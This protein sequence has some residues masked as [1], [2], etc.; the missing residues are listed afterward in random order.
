MRKHQSIN[1]RQI[2]RN[3]A[4]QMAYYRFL[5]NEKGKAFVGQAFE[6]KLTPMSYGVPLPRG[7][8]T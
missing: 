8:F 4:E 2:S 6:L 7:L 5:E 3:W 1:I